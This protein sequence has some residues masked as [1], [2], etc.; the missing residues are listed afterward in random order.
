MLEGARSTKRERKRGQNH[1]VFGHPAARKQF[2]ISVRG[3]LRS[4]NAP[5]QNAFTAPDVGGYTRDAAA[6]AIPRCRTWPSADGGNCDRQGAET[7]SRTV[8][9]G[10]I[11]TFRGR[12]ASPER[13]ANVATYWPPGTLSIAQSPPAVWQVYVAA[14]SPPERAVSV[15]VPSTGC[16]AAL[17]TWTWTRAAASATLAEKTTTNAG[18]SQEHQ[19]SRD[20][21]AR[22]VR[23]AE[24]RVC[25]VCWDGAA[26]E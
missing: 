22:R 18:A 15:T 11:I 5:R 7:R 1:C 4:R 14:A 17:R 24:G 23:G 16:P 12:G 9:A 8:P 20:G 10:G 6:A 19:E 3:A 2:E 26:G 25:P 13:G 21:Q